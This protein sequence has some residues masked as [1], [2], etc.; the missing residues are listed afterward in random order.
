MRAALASL[1]LVVTAGTAYAGVTRDTLWVVTR[2][3]VAAQATF[4]KPFPCLHV[5]LGGHDQPGFAVLKAP[6]LK[7]EVVVMPTARIV[8]LED[9]SLRQTSGAAYWR[10]ATQARHFV[11]DALQG[12]L[13]I[14]DVAFAVN[15]Q[16]G[17]SQ[18]QLHIHLDCVQ[19]AVRAT[20]RANATAFTSEWHPLPFP[21]ERERYYGKLVP[22][23]ALDGLNPFAELARLPGLHDL[24]ATSF[25]MVSTSPGDPAQGAYL[26]AYRA[27]DSHAEWLLD[28]DCAL[29]GKTA[30][31]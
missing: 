11:T 23:D 7:T 17:R 14:S 16:G 20:L 5:D 25:A 2:T 3:C 30:A 19:P 29:A 18:D 22:A 27:A 24:R 31:H 8:G 15:S 13:D 1:A 9:R 12:R 6:L 28:H 26:L 21:L 4:G 10:A